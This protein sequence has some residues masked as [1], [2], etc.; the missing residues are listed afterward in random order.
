MNDGLGVVLL[1]EDTPDHLTLLSKALDQAGYVVLSASDGASALRLLETMRPDVILLDAL[2][3]GLD[4]F[5][6]CARI[7][8]QER[9]RQ[10]PV[11]FMTALTDSAH[12]LNGFAQGA[13]DYITKPIR[14]DELVVRLDTHLRTARHLRHL[15]QALETSKQAVLVTNARGVMVWRSSLAMELLASQGPEFSDALTHSEGWSQW[16]QPGPERSG[17]TLSYQAGE[18]AFK[19]MAR[20][21][22]DEYLVMV[23]RSEAEASNHLAGDLARRFSLTAREAEVLQ[24]ATY[25]KASRDIAQILAMSPRTVDKHFEHILEKLGVENRTSAVAMVLHNSSQGTAD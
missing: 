17:A 7:K 21:S 22:Q 15:Y 23:E 16:L 20:Y 12:V 8:K 6:T 19:L 3:P 5:E 18:L 4:G 10:V 9:L 14:I 11:I 25:G 2:M 13:I 1:V 24:W